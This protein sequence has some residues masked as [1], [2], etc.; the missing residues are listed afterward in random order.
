MS[1][2]PF[3]Q[4]QIHAQGA[5]TILWR[6]NMQ[7]CK[8]GH[9]QLPCVIQQG[10]ILIFFGQ[11]SEYTGRNAVFADQITIFAGFQCFHIFTITNITFANKVFLNHLKSSLKSP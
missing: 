1:V 3:Q 2:Q 7:V 5:E 4:F 11:F 9:N 8:T 10:E 6:M